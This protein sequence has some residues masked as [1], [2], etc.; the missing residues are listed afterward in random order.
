MKRGLAKLWLG[1]ISSL[2]VITMI[3]GIIHLIIKN[4]VPVFLVATAA[5][6]VIFTVLSIEE[7]FG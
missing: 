1:F 7:I 4:P 3:V 2:A 5:A 6:V